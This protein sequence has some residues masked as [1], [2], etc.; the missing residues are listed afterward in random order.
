M[1]K[2]PQ[3]QREQTQYKRSPR[4]QA[5]NE[6]DPKEQAQNGRNPKEQ[7]QNGRDT[8]GME[9]SAKLP[10]VRVSV[11][12]LV[13]FILRSGDI[14]NR[15]G[16]PA[17]REAMLEGGRLHRRIQGRMGS[18]YKAEVPLSADILFDGFI[19]TVE[20]RADGVI[21]GSDVY[22]DE[23][24]GVYRD[25]R[26]MEEPV[27]VHLAQAKCYAHIY[28]S[29]HGLSEI[30]VQMTYSNLVSEEVRRFRQMYKAEELAEWFGELTGEYEKWM[31]YQI[32][33]KKIRQASCKEAEFPFPWRKGQKKLSQDVY[34][35]ILRRKK[36][37]IQA[38]TGTGKTISTV[39]PAVKAIGEGIAD[40]IFYMTAKTI[41]RTVAA[42]A[43][44]ILREQ[45][46]RMKVLTLTSK[47]KLC[48]C[49]ETECNPEYCPYARGH[50]D[51]VND[52]VYEMIT[53]TD[54]FDREA[55]IRQAQKWMVCPFEFSLDVSL[56]VDAVIC[57]YNYVFSPRVKLKRFFA[58]GT[59]GEYLFLIDEAHNLVDRGRDM[60]SAALYQEDFQ[61]LEKLAEPYS[62][63]IAAALGKCGGYLRERRRE[64]EKENRAGGPAYLIQKEVGVFSIH[65]MNLCGVIEDYLED[66]REGR[67][68]AAALKK[69]AGQ[70]S[71]EKETARA[72]D[73]AFSPE[74]YAEV[75]K[76]I[77]DF[78]FQTLT[79]LDVCDRLD[80]NYVIYTELCEDRRF[81]I[82]LYC[83]DVSRNLQ[84]CLDM[85]KSTIYFS[86]T[87]LP[88]NYYKSLLSTAEDDY[89][90]YAQSSFD[91]AKCRVLIGMDTSS[92]YEDR[93]ES[94]YRKM[95][96][97]VLETIHA[98]EGNYMAFFPSYQML[99]YV[100]RA[101]EELCGE[102]GIR[103]TE[104]EEENRGSREN[105]GPGEK[106]TSRKKVRTVEILRQT[107]GMNERE[108]EEFLERFRAERNGS[109]V[110]FCVMGGVFGEGIDLKNDRL[111][112]AV[113]VGTG[114]PKVCN[115]RQILKKFY[116]DR[117]EDGFFYAYLCPGMNKVLQSAGRVIRTD[118]DRGVILLLDRR[119][120]QERYRKMLPGEWQKPQVCG[121]KSVR[122][123]MEEFWISNQ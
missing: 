123:K 91:P 108:R 110:G 47:E 66:L 117:G 121:V 38:P 30:G 73:P 58:E 34:R 109:L 105:G 32:E 86:A 83:V 10:R 42:N 56:W 1:E 8:S 53:G 76:K 31:R 111:I 85:G 57:D 14:D 103:L 84:E 97:Y 95:A 33:W 106:G 120:I 23:I 27:P 35:T 2:M 24:K 20:G 80:D 98:R 93:S 50:F 113:I 118:E 77:L 81:M 60:F 44:A 59:K 115:E 69:A 88:I 72:K 65:L 89:A 64:T 15:R 82:K 78:Y 25:L 13:E 12:E 100:A 52:A 43:F 101:F 7:I 70:D 51:R 116:D 107:A 49:E 94:E 22:I 9:N 55:L 79:F 18:N 21:T 62:K 87:F 122:G 3:K 45:G 37:F 67:G 61:E 112:G 63:K 39:F 36:L 17:D 6:R 90:I 92:R 102:E 74:K 19:L 26:H 48:F 40:R 29:G 96:R 11:R 5:Q 16:G 75:N 46:L 99:D 104:A 41:T 28:A 68:P 114:I 54:V 4:E 119:F 71:A